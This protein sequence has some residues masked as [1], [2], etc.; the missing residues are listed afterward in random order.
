M[1]GD[2]EE[3][4]TRAETRAVAEVDGHLSI[5]RFT[6]GWKVMFGTPNL[7]DGDEASAEVSRLPSFPTLEEALQAL[8]AREE[9]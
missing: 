5:F 8:L 7:R 9:S 1:R 3:L 4:L 6:N 2:L